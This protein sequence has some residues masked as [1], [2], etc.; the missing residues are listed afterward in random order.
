[1]KLRSWLPL[2]INVEEL[3]KDLLKLCDK[4][5]ELGKVWVEIEEMEVELAKK[6]A[7]LRSYSE[8]DA[9]IEEYARGTDQL[10]KVISDSE[11]S[12]S[13]LKKCKTVDDV[14]KWM[15]E[16]SQK[17]AV[18]P[19]RKREKRVLSK[20]E[21]RRIAYKAASELLEEKC[22]ISL[23]KEMGEVHTHREGAHM[24][25]TKTGK[26]E[27]CG[28]ET[29]WWVSFIHEGKTHWNWMCPKCI[30][31][32][33][34]LGV[35]PATTRVITN[36]PIKIEHPTVV[37]WA[38]FNNGISIVLI[39]DDEGALYLSPMGASEISTVMKRTEQPI[40]EEDVAK[41]MREGTPYNAGDLIKGIIFIDK[42]LEDLK[43]KVI[44]T[45]LTIKKDYV[46]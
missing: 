15:D 20:S 26:C 39:E 2:S 30:E 36:P 33:K 44:A 12:F 7:F 28:S 27:G 31:D 41:M 34:P 23:P 16:H 8:A 37:D 29:K 10:R 25:A 22:G 46:I 14:K 4:E 43:N 35:Y 18:L 38:F 19:E 17:K 13:D 5:I 9:D 11:K 42:N 6:Y 21:E 40:P 45:S 32:R 24:A 1:M 3:K